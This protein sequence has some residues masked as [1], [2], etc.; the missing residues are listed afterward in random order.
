MP[1]EVPVKIPTYIA[2][3]IGY[4]S[5]YEFK[6]ISLI[7]SRPLQEGFNRSLFFFSGESGW[8]VGQDMF[9][10]KSYHHSTKDTSIVD[11]GPSSFP[12]MRWRIGNSLKLRPLQRLLGS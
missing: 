8:K 6:C 5:N 9:S 12:S 3:I 7:A 2:Q 11:P 4:E 10:L 1:I